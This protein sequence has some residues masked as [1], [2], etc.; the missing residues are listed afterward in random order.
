MFADTLTI[1]INSVA[2]VLTRVNT[3]QDFASEYRLRGTLDE[4]RLRIKHSSYTDKASGKVM[5]RHSVELVQT[6]YPVAPAVNSSIRKS[7]CV[8]E[9]PANDVVTDVLNYDL[10]FV[11]FF[12][13][14]N[15]TK[16]LNYES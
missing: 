1:T 16:L 14:P 8:L 6:I 9:E 15:L 11:G 13:S 2:K 7:Y 5:N 10:G 4:F 3:G 12:T